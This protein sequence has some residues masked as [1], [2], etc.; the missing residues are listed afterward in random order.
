MKK[1]KNIHPGD[2]LL[3]DFMKPLEL[4]AYR[5]AKDLHVSQ[6]R[7]GEILKGQRSVTPEMALRL[8]TW[9]GSTPHFWL[10]LQEAYDLEEA[11]RSPMAKKIAAEVRPMV[12]T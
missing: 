6:T 9:C 12:A 10:N 11:Q 5:V 1:L 2:V 4:T 7:L 3:E 8:A